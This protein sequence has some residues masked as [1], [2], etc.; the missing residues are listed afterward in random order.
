VIFFISI[1]F[2]KVDCQNQ[3]LEDILGGKDIGKNL[4]PAHISFDYITFYLA[5][6]I[7]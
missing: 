7:I 2:I 4:L 6:Y 5:F 3:Y 1:F